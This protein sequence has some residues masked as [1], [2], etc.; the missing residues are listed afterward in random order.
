MPFGL[1]NLGN[2]QLVLILL[3]R[4][5]IWIP[6][7]VLSGAFGRLRDSLDAC[8]VCECS[9]E[10]GRKN[11]KPQ[12]LCGKLMWEFDTSDV[13]SDLKCVRCINFFVESSVHENN[14]R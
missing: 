12:K 8:F 9:S 13:S 6:S 5:L 10:M 11:L 4:I 14:D 3:S 7:P 2:W 1:D